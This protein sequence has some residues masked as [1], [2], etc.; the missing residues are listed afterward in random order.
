MTSL[1]RVQQLPMDG[2]RRGGRSSG[3]QVPVRHAAVGAL[4]HRRLDSGGRGGAGAHV[5]WR[6]LKRKLALFATFFETFN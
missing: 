3:R 4:L 2:R 6:V 1:T 5:V